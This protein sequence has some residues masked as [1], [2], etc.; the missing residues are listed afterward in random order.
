MAINTDKRS[1][2]T[3]YPDNVELDRAITVA[4]CLGVSVSRYISD[5]IKDGNARMA[6]EWSSRVKQKG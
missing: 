4:N 1:K 3:F 5:C 6:E 2:F